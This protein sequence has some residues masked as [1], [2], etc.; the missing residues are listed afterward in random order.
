MPQ[1]RKGPQHTET[2]SASSARQAEFW[3]TLGLQVL[4][5]NP[6]ATL[7]SDCGGGLVPKDAESMGRED[8]P[9]LDFSK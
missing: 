5:R 7:Y 3:G 2:P 1:A 6:A 9:L 4:I 8:E